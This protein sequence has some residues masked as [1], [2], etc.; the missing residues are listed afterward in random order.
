MYR[1]TRGDMIEMFKIMS[2]VYDSEV[3]DFIPRCRN[4]VTRGHKYKI[5]HR[6]AHLNVRKNWFGIR[7]TTM[8]NNLPATVVN[9]PNV[10]TFEK[11]LDKVWKNEDFKF[12]YHAQPPTSRK[13]YVVNEL[14]I[15]A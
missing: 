6:Y 11:R 7:N 2:G 10:K 1:R 4:S 15:E 3:A 5:F 12:D 13:S 9:S 14:D 8:W